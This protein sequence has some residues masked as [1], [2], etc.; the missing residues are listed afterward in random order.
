MQLDVSGIQKIHRK[1]NPH[2]PVPE[3]AQA[4]ISLHMARC[5]AMNIPR[6]LRAYSHAWLAEQNIKWVNGKWEFGPR[7]ETAIAETVGIASKSD[8]PGLS[9]K[10][11]IAMSDAL[12]NARA[13]GRDPQTFRG[14]MLK[15]RDKVR[16]KLRHI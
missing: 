5:H 8:V 9:R 3:A 14:L 1:T 16:F 10:I 15:A 4:L 6:R 2:L 7:P 12:D 11:V 13:K